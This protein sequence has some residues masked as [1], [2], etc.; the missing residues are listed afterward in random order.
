M[1]VNFLV[2]GSRGQ[3]GTELAK[4]LKKRNH[5]FELIDIEEAD[6]IDEQ[7]VRLIIEKINPRIII[8][9]AAYTDVGG[10]ETNKQEAE[11]VNNIGA[12]NVAIATKSIG[13]RMI[14]ISTDYVFDGN[15]GDYEE[16]HTTNPINEYG[17]SKEL[18]EKAVMLVN[19]KNCV[20]RTAFLFGIAKS[21]IKKTNC[22]ENFIKASER[23]GLI[24]A[25]KDQYFN[26]TYAK[27]LAEKI[28]DIA[29]RIEEFSGIYNL[30]NKGV[31][32]WYEFAKEVMKEAKIDKEVIPIT[33]EE[34]KKL[35]IYKV[36]TPKN[37]TLKNVRAKSKGIEL[38]DWKTG[39]REYINEKKMVTA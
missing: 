22:V 38:S 23:E 13:A 11:N 9:T 4:I 30:T 15:E 7:K 5:S 34:A 32:N 39:L 27:E 21:R 6:I 37:T 28:I 26:A 25:V 10:C 35:G 12:K 17:K 31:I 18:G 2:T 14:H 16:Y 33:M 20:V 24:R 36:N 19:E 3:L 1:T 8:H 29:E